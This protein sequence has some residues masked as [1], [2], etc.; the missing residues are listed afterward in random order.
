MARI[1][2][3]VT[4]VT[5]DRY[6]GRVGTLLGWRDGRP[7]VELHPTGRAKKRTIRALSLKH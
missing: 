5:K 3:I 6:D 1:N 2:D 4:V 7:V